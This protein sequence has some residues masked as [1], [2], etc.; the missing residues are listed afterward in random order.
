MLLEI[1]VREKSAKFIING[2]SQRKPFW[3]Q[4]VKKSR[5]IFGMIGE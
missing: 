5:H 2:K 1:G 3:G 4:F